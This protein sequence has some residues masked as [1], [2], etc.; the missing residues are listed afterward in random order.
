VTDNGGATGS[1]TRSITLIPPNVPPTASFTFG[2]TGLV[3]TFNGSSSTDSDGTIVSYS[4]AFG[5]GTAGSGVSASHMY[6]HSGTY[7]A[8]LKVT[9]DRGASTTLS[10]DVVVTN[11]APTAAFTTTCTGLHCTLDAG[12]SADTDGVIAIY[13]WSFGDGTAGAVMTKSTT[14]DY[15]KAGSYTVTLTVTDNDGASAFV[16]KRINPISLSARGYKQ[17]GQQKVDLSWNGSSGASFDL[18]RNG[19]KIATVA[20]S[21]YTDNVTNKGPGSYSY[22]VCGVAFPSCSDQVTVSF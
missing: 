22:K 2:C 20:A 5:D 19:T 12:G 1:A 4:W 9:D 7:S 6:G 13:S 17:N 11:I 21:A 14:H 16:T 8:S 3:C 10:K 15:P 18:Y